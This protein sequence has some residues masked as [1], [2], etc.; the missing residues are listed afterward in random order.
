[1]KQ[2][3]VFFLIFLYSFNLNSVEIRTIKL[4]LIVN[5]SEAYTSFLKN[6]E[7]DKNFF[8]VKLQKNEDKFNAK[9][10]EIENSKIILSQE[11][12]DKKVKIF[13]ND[14]RDF[15]IKIDDI[16]KKI[17]N[18]LESNKAILINQIAEIVQKIS[19]E[20]K[21]D[22]VFNENQYFLSNSY[23]DIS[24]LVIQYLNTIKIN[25]SEIEIKLE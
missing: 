5:N 18:Y 6:F 4:S 14:A 20:K 11:E 12:Y 25:F 1:M 22:I 10:Q 13:N 8:F 2:S 16:N 15:Q 23:I 7:N 17:E 21:I 9:K 3:I 19:E 24:D